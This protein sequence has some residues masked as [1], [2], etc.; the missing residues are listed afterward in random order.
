MN[1]ELDLFVLLCEDISTKSWVLLLLFEGLFIGI[2][3]SRRQ[4]C[5]SSDN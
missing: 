3:V 5:N 4:G 2:N 1:Y